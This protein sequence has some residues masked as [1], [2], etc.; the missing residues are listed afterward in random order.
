M[1]IEIERKYLLKED[2]W[3]KLV[4]RSTQMAQGYL[5]K[6]DTASVRVRIEDERANI[7][8]KSMTLGIERLEYEYP[9]P[10]TEAREMLQ[11]L[12]GGRSVTK[13][14][15]YVIFEGKTW[16]IDEFSGANAGLIVAEIEL[17]SA[18]E[19]IVLP[20]WLGAE[21]SADKRYYNV[22]LLEQPY[23]TWAHK[24]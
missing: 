16:E 6:N 9:V 7:N 3:R 13:T 11:H 12:C 8:I 20:P 5:S 22:C 1:A 4:T 19:D 23:T 2:S 24:S 15:H 18:D 17:K 14:R 21:V 10:L